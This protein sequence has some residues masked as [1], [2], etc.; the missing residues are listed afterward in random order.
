MALGRRRPL[1]GIA[2]LIGAGKDTLAARLTSRWGFER[3]GFAVALKAEV[4]RNFRRTLLAI[5]NQTEAAYPEQDLG[6]ATEDRIIDLLIDTKPPIVRE[7]LQEYGTEVRRHDHLDY[8]VEAWERSLIPGTR[9]VAPDCRFENEANRIRALGGYL[10]LVQRPDRPM[11][12][13]ASET[14]T[15]KWPTS[16]FDHVFV[17]GG[18]IAELHDGLDRWVQRTLQEWT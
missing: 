9:V 3:V 7:L 8:W 11:G 4:R 16:A 12:T 5:W 6:A 1:I 17:N 14:G 15:A 18:T 13:H 2:G 10:W